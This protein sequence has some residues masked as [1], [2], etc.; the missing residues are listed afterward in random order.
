MTTHWCDDC[1]IHL[2]DDRN[3]LCPV[4][5]SRAAKNAEAAVAVMV[6]RLKGEEA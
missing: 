1:G 4:C 5:Q 6:A 3:T 2:A